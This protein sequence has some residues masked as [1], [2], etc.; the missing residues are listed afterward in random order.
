M[1]G[2]A[3]AH[4]DSWG[5]G[6]FAHTSPVYVAAGGEWRLYDPATAQYML[7]LVEGSLAYIRQTAPRHPHGRVTHHHGEEDHLAHLEAPFHE[8]AAIPERM[9]EMGISH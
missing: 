7:T 5:R 1:P 2:I 8:E 6:I 3:A 4:H 9:H